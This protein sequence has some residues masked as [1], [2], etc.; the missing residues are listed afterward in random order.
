MVRQSDIQ[1]AIL[2]TSA[3]IACLTW[4][5]FEKWQREKPPPKIPVQAWDKYVELQ[6]KSGKDVYY[7]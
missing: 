4:Y 2:A 3:F 5:G 6:K 7:I 1:T